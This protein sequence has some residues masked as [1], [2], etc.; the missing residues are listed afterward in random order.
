M[1]GRWI[2]KFSLTSCLIMGAVGCNRNTV[3]SSV[4]DAQPVQGV[5]MAPANNKSL[6][7]NSTPHAAAAVPVEVPAEAARKGPVKPETEVAIADL[8]LQLALDEKTQ[9]GQRAGLLDLARHGYQKALQQDSKNKAAMLGLARYYSRV[10][11]REKSVEMYEK[12]VAIN[13]S[14]REAMH[15][16]AITYARWQDWNNAVTWCN[17]ALKIDPENLSY[18]KTKAFCLARAGQWEEAFKVFLNNMH[19]PEAQARYNIARVLEHQNHSD[20]ARQQVQ[21]ALQ[22]DPSLADARDLLAE[23]DQKQMPAAPNDPNAIQRTGFSQ[24]Q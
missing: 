24:E 1:A 7:G 21:L 9:D 16:I 20:L 15:E 10:G 8:R 5:P 11:E 4:A 22:I 19:M 17:R 12:Y 23:M 13:P 18:S 14:D 2:Y 3:Q 6:W